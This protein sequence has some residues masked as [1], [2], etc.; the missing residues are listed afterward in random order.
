MSD[1]PALLELLHRA[2]VLLFV[3]VTMMLMT[4]TLA[5]RMRIRR[6]FFSWATG[7]LAGLPLL[8]TLFLALVVPAFGYALFADSLHPSLQPLLLSGYLV[9]GIFWYVS[10]LV[11]QSMTVTDFGL[12]RNVNRVG[13][14]I[15]WGQVEDY[16]LSEAYGS[17]HYI[18]LYV[19][20]QGERRRLELSVPR[21]YRDRFR[22]IVATKVD[23]RF[24]FVLERTYGKTALNR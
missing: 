21:S 19:D 9:G 3:A 12:I 14:A 17:C 8:P 4:V 22:Q 24:Q 15:A 13:Q 6:V 20:R 7:R 1:L 10:A 5:N 11:A 23:A 16:F 18:F 2:V